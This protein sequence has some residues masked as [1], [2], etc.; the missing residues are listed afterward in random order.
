LFK[1]IHEGR[2]PATLAELAKAWDSRSS[3]TL[4][5]QPSPF[6]SDHLNKAV[7]KLPAELE[8]NHFGLLTS[9]ST[10]RPKVV[11]G[12]KSRTAALVAEIERRQ[13]LRTVRSTVMALPLSYSYGFVNQWLWAHLS[14]RRLIATA[15]LADP[16][17]FLE[18]LDREIDTMLCLVGSQ[19]P[20]LRNFLGKG[21]RFT[22]VI[23]LNFAGGP[24]PQADL[25]WLEETFPYARILHNFG[26][27]E[28][29]P[30]LTIR[31]ARDRDDP[32]VLGPLVEGAELSLSEGG[33]LAFRSPYGAV[34][35]VDGESV[36]LHDPTDWI[37]TGDAAEK[38]EDGAYRLLGRKSDVFKR[39]G[40]KVSLPILAA[41]LREV[42]PGG[43]VFY[44]DPSE[45][46]EPAHVLLLSPHPNNEA[47]QIIL[48]HLRTH[49]RRPLWPVR[50][51]A[52]AEIP[53]SRNGKP[54]VEAIR[55]L[56]RNVMWKQR[57]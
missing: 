34:A 18:A 37:E 14:Q 21:R 32:L 39:F 49:F 11:I 51:E 15:G 1:L 7:S 12:R 57:L 35:I 29:L 36:R 27:A 19:V 3:F 30:R 26:C 2:D 9:G 31:D 20:I 53:L 48:R 22:N 56:P 42:W 50:L 13:D 17:G 41:S 10:G 55:L 23:R 16:A 5:P 24:F 46:G 54:D 45:N 40:E 33:M 43:L 38:L 44:L 28:A 52:A 6:S 4:A 25:A 47:V 8:E